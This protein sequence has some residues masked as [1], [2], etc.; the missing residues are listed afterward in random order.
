[1]SATDTNLSPPLAPSL[2]APGALARDLAFWRPR[3]SAPPALLE[4]PADRPPSALAS[5]LPARLEFSFSKDLAGQLA[6]FCSRLGLP[7][8]RFLLPAYAVLLSRLTGRSDVLIGFWAGSAS[9]EGNGVR[10]GSP[11]AQGNLIALA[12]EAT[13]GTPFATLADRL[14]LDLEEARGY[15]T[16][17]WEYLMAEFA[18]GRDL[19]RD[20]V[21]AAYFSF[22]LER[23]LAASALASLERFQPPLALSF[24]SSPSLSASVLY[25]SSRFDASTIQRILENFASLLASALADPQCDVARLR[26]I[27]PAEISQLVAWNHTRADYPAGLCVH[28]LVE[29]SV[30]RSPGAIAIEQGAMRVTYAELD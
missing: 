15:S 7:L 9:G 20:P 14:A 22:S 17:K 29:S 5:W 16:T 11:A 19:L 4:L 28:Q 18:P 30:D 8:E 13:P 6:A 12:A 25:D 26:L 27:T 1:M 24:S 2:G 10:L 21:I 23:D 3:L